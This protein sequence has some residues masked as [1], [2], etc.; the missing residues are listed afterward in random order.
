MWKS[1]YKPYTNF[2]IESIENK[3]YHPKYPDKIRD[4]LIITF[5]GILLF[6]I[7]LMVAISGISPSGW[8]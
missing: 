6:I 2:A 8:Y 7:I 4:I 3:D 5:M 1:V